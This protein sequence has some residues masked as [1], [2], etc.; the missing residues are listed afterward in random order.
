M[1]AMTPRQRVRAALDHQEPDRVPTAIGGG[2]YGIVDELYLKLVDYFQLGQPVRPFRS[3]HNISYMDDRLFERLGVD[4]RYIWPG[5]SPSDPLP[6]ADNPDELIDAYGQPWKRA[7]PYYYPGNG[8]LAGATLDDIETRVKWPDAN[9]PRWT[10]GVRDRAQMLKESSDYFVVA[11]MVTSHGPY[12]TASHLRGD[13]QFFLDMAADAKFTLGLVERV[14]DSLV[15][16]LRKYL[17]ACGP[18]IEMIE[19]PGDDYATQTGMAMSPKMFRRYFKPSIKRLVDTVKTY[20]A[21]IKVMQ[22]CDG[23]LTPILPDL[24]ALGIDVVHP[25]EPLPAM[26]LAEAKSQFGDRLAFLGGIDIVRALPGSRQDVVDEVRQRISQLARGGGYV[27][28][29]ANHVQADVPVENLVTL[30]EA[31]RRYGSYPIDVNSISPSLE[32]G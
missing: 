13:K 4:T 7:A 2:P 1:A 27:L 3:G 28:A 17:E 20:R 16:L 22:H 14:T 19:L 25:L 32:H 5:S 18:Y 21:D 8:L 31:A 10:A 15:Q 29:P 9:D 30:F 26:N 12:M 6:A 23:A 11:R 24:V